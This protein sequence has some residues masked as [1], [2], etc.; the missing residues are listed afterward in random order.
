MSRATKSGLRPDLH[1]LWVKLDALPDRSVVI[2]DRGYAWQKSAYLNLWYRAFDGEGIDA[3][4]L[5]GRISSAFVVHQ[6]TPEGG[7]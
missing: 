2:D 1:R 5:M 4:T 6:P 7:A 3:W